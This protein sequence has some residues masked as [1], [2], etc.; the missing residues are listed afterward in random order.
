MKDAEE[1]STLRGGGRLFQR[2]GAEDLKEPVSLHP[3]P[4][5]CAGV[6]CFHTTGCKTYSFTTDGY[7][8]FNVPQL[9]MRPVGYTHEGGV[10]VRYKQAQ[11]LTRSDIKLF[12]AP[13]CPA[14]GSN[15]GYFGSEFRL[16]VT[17]ELR[18]LSAPRGK[19]K[20]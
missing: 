1:E 5:L 9:W 19:I 18:P 8:I 14:R 13:P 20:F 11:E 7:E 17:T 10:G 15:L 6:S 2:A 4:P 16:P 3:P 12:L